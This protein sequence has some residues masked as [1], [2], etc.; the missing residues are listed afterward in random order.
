MAYRNSLMKKLNLSKNAIKKSGKESANAAEATP[1]IADIML[2]P[3][4]LRQ[5]S[6]LIND[7]LQKGFDVL[8]LSDGNIIMT[9]TKTIVHTYEW[10][11]EKGKLLKVKTTESGGTVKRARKS[12]NEATTEEE[13][14]EDA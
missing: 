11:M 13:V 4:Y 10:E 12:K 9:G 3:R 1:N 7:A 5:S 2:D 6:A 14:G 8:Q